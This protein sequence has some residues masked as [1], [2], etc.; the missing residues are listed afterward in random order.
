MKRR[1]IL[2]ALL[3]L[4]LWSI[5]VLPGILAANPGFWDWR[6]V[7]VHLSGVLALWWMSAGMVL[8]VRPLWLEKRLG[9]LDRLY[10]LHKYLRIGSGIL[11]FSHWM[12]EWLPKK[13]AKPGRVP[14]TRPGGLGA[15]TGAKT[16]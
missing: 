5:F 10:R 13:L 14:S 9:G 16:D 8:A 15:F 12:I 6:R 3:P 11:V 7:L 1:V 4:G 2:L